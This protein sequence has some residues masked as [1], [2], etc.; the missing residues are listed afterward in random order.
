MGYYKYDCIILCAQQCR[1]A[2]C[3][4][5]YNIYE[6]GYSTGI[7][8]KCFTRDKYDVTDCYRSDGYKKEDLTKGIYYYIIKESFKDLLKNYT[9]IYEE[10]VG[11]DY[12]VSHDL[13]KRVEKYK[14]KFNFKCEKLAGGGNS[15]SMSYHVEASLNLILIMSF[16]SVFFYF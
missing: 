6:N 3:I 13:V 7:S 9:N 11:K 2:E 10:T 15:K 12:N 14:D 4:N 8:Q 1:K 16:F 5:P